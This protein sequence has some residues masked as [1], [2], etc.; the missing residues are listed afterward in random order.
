MRL[1]LA[2]SS[3]KR[4]RR[5]QCTSCVHYTLYAAS[6]LFVGL[7]FSFS[8]FSYAMTVVVSATYKIKAVL[9]FKVGGKRRYN[10]LTN[11]W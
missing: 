3:L 9:D 4:E 5:V 8:I 2:L 10:P 6:H 11:L 1:A 7:A